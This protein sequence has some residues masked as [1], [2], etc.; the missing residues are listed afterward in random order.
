MKSD[1]R[2]NWKFNTRLNHP[3]RISPMPGNPPLLAPIYHSV[4]FVVAEGMPYWDQ[5]IYGRVSNPT[6]RQLE[7]LLAD[8]Q[9]KED[10]IV[11]SSGIAAITGSMLGLLK[12]GDHVIT[13]RELYKPARIFMRDMLPRFGITTSVL[14]LNQLDDLEKTIIPGKTKLIHFESPTNPNLDIADI[15]RI[16]EVAHKNNVLVSMDGTF[17]GIHQHTDFDI[18]LMIHSLTKFANGHGDVL[19][20]SIAGKKA[21]IQQIRQMTITLGATLDPQAAALVERGLKTYQLRFERHVK[22]AG[23]VAEFLNQHP[24]IK[25]V[26]YP[27]LTTHAGYELAQKQM[28]DMGAVVSFVLD[29]SLGLNADQFAHKLKLI[30]FAVSLGATESII[31]PTHIF[32]GDD[33]GPVDKEEMGIS[34]HSLRLSVGLEDAEDVIEDLKQA[35]SL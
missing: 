12:S 2:K 16:I 6:V 35:L 20:G 10:C 24:K 21:L 9:N 18:D 19:A 34:P 26:F 17:A 3:E 28:S 5:F 27:G 11:L 15:H 23:K 33:L 1:N 31:C 29:S 7:V 4:K 32:F 30:Q 13:F 25:K 8:L 14:K 22:N